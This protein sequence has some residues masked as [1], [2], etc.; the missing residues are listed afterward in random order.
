MIP[1]PFSASRIPPMKPASWISAF[2]ATA[3]LAVAAE[4]FDIVV[5]G[6]TSGGVAAAVQA[7]RDGRSVVLVSPTEHLG[8]M[9]SSG[10]GWTDLGRSSILGG[11]SRDFYHR[12]YL[13]YQADEAWNWQS[14][15]SYGNTGQ[16][17][18]AF[19]H[20]TQ[21]ASVFEPKVAEAVF[22]QW[23]AEDDVTVVTGRLD[24]ENGVTMD[25][26]R[27]ASIQLEDGRGFAGKMFID[28]TYEGDL[29]PGAGVTFTI[30]R[31]SNATYNETVNGIQAGNATKNQLPNGID[32]Y[33]VPGEESSGLLPGVNPNAGGPDGAAD[34]RLQAYCYRMVLTDVA[35]NR[36]A[37]GQPDDYDEADYELLFRAIEAGQNSGF[38]KFD[39]M[40]NRK[41]DSNNTGGISTDYIGMNYGE[42]WNWATLGHDARAALAKRHENWQRG[43]VWTLQN[44]E[45][46]PAAIRN[47]HAKWGLPAD[48]FADNGHWPYQ[49][50]VRE[51]RRMVSDY[52]MTQHHCQRTVVAP[53]SVGL[54]AYAMD[55][56]NTQRHVRDG[57][58]K[59]EGDVQL[60]LP[61]EYPVSYRSLVPKKGECENL[62]VPWSLSASHM[63]FGSIRMEPVFMIL[64][65]SAAIA[66]DLALDEEIAVQDVKYADLRPRLVEAGQAL[67]E[68]VV[69][70][71]TSFVD[72]S[73]AQLVQVTGDW[74]SSASTPGYAGGDYLHDDNAGQGGKSVF[75]RVAAGV[76]GLHKVS[77]RWTAHANRA[78]NVRVEIRH[79]D[80][81]SVRTV[82]QRANGGTWNLLGTFPFTGAE[83]EGV[84]VSNV[85]ANGYVIADAVGYAPVAE[86][87]DDT[88][89][90][91]LSDVD[92]L[93]LGLDP[94]TSDVPF[95]DAVRANPSFFGL[96]APEEIHELHLS[97]PLFH[98]A[99]RVDFSLHE[100][101]GT[102]W[103][104]VADLEMPV[105]TTA[106]RRFF[107]IE[108]GL[109]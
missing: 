58:V 92:E 107:R 105:E 17:G 67:G 15:A 96:H 43:L 99:G 82:D 41:T 97:Q 53:D 83:D 37:V 48:E 50:Y 90:D 62:L 7:A 87:S 52:V 86:P 103:T 64:A 26:S 94:Y 56:H 42:D 54:A 44:H 47:N 23:I 9:T 29:L 74:L 39:L 33:V 81:T 91:G 32:P 77:L 36:V 93:I 22:A 60:A 13:H 84:L 55:S 19:N 68:P 51:A 101:N 5:Y 35:E 2:L 75:F 6:G 10:L 49:L 95:I 4:N 63:A 16:G 57:M 1:L 71:P 11:L 31:E 70:P 66:A 3:P 28:A 98:R 40:P 21:V 12:I 34:E 25:G 30:G 61:G 38:F 78:S 20:S 104:G 27:I 8:G 102:G 88:D 85:G 14:Q 24:L 46:V 65:Q 89:A 80:G 18:P 59:N 108:A 45:R 72:N 79:R 109:R 76:D 73:D 100:W 106:A 69:D